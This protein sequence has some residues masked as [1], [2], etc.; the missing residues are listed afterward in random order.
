MGESSAQTSSARGPRPRGARAASC[1]IVIVLGLSVVA[2]FKLLCLPR[3]IAGDAWRICCPPTLWP[4]LDYNMYDRAYYPGRSF[5]W[6]VLV[7]VDDEGH[8]V[9]LEPAPDGRGFED[10][11]RRDV[12]AFLRLDLDVLQDLADA[13]SD[14]RTLRRLRLED[15]PRVL[16]EDGRLHY[17]PTQ[18]PRQVRIVDGVVRR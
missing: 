14:G 2:G 5:P 3:A 16:G 4:F 11:R 9:L 10:W 18:V 6:Y 8:E 13:H 1:V 7:G 17:D 15:H 12:P